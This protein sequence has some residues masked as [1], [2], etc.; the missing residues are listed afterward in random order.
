MSR[1]SARRL[2]SLALLLAAHACGAR[3][4]LPTGDQETRDPAEPFCGDHLRNGAEEC[5]DAND[6]ST[7]TC[8]A[9]AIAACGDGVVFAGVEGCDDGN[10]NGAD[11]CRSDCTL[12]SCGDG[13]LDPLEDCDD[14]NGIDTDDCPRN[15]LFAKCGD[16]FVRDGVE[17]CDLGP[18]N[19][20][21]PAFLLT[22]GPLSRGVR[23]VD[24]AA[25]AEGFY[26]YQSAS[27]HTGFEALGSSLMYLYRDT[28][29]GVLSL[30][31]HHGVDV[32]S[33]GIDQPKSHVSMQI[34]HLPSQVLVSVADDKEDEFF[35][36]TTESA[37][38]DWDFGSNTDGGALSGLPV[39]G[40]W[41]VDVIATFIQ[42]ITVWSYLEGDATTVPLDGA[43]IANLSAFETP[44]ACRLDCTVPACGDGRL[45]GG[46]VCDDGNQTNGDGC[47]S[48]CKSLF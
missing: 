40:S 11:G 32:D 48:T 27:S 42:G 26:G 14:G 45:D 41:S 9:C 1:R 34:L 12:P 6:V 19:D 3:T 13:L 16:G 39:P 37:L 46:E 23:P 43:A 2:L 18:L 20:D 7:D 4:S 22:Q 31:L 30:F 47:A 8:L 35:K 44:S 38:G 29:T 10:S 24:R 21:R 36:N 15:C 33:T 5:D 25:S 17:A 28:T